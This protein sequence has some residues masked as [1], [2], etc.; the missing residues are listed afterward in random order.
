MKK[1]TISRQKAGADRFLP[2]TKEECSRRGWDAPDFVYAVGEAYVDHPSFGHAIISRVLEK[3]GYKVAMLCL[4]DWHTCD[5]FKR[6]GRPK[7]GYLVTAGVI[8]SMVNHYTAAKRRRNSDVYAPGGKS[9]MRPDRAVTVYCNRIHEAYP[10]LPILIGGVEASLRRFSHYDYWDDKVRR[11]VLVD[12]SATLLMYG[13]GEKSILECA[14]WLRDG[15]PAEQLPSIRGVCYMSKT[16]PEDA[17]VLPSHAEVTADKKAYAQSVIMEYDEA[18]PFRGRTLTQMQDTQR[19]LVQNPPVLPL[20]EKELDAVYDLPY[21]RAYHPVYE[22]EGGVPALQEVRFSISAVRGCFGACSFCALTFHQGRIVQ[23]RSEESLLKEARMLTQ[24]PDFKGYIHDVG[25]P[26]ANFRL[27]SCQKQ[28]K[29]GCCVNRQCLFPKPCPHMTVSHKAFLQTLRKMRQIPGVKKVFVRS[30]LRFDYIMADPEREKVIR[31][32]C[33]YHIS[34][35]LK[36]APEHISDA[37]LEQM[38][39]PCN[40]VYEQFGELYAKTNEQ[41]GMKQYL[42]PYLMSSHPGSTL[43]DAVQLALYLKHKGVQPEQ[44]QDFY[45]T[46]GT[47]S[48]CAYY[49][50]LDPRTMKPVF[51]PKTQREKDMQRALLQ[52][53]EP[54]NHPLIR[55]ALRQCGREDLIGYGHNALVPPAHSEK[56]A[57]V[58]RNP[59]PKNLRKPSK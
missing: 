37:V 39:K 34:G 16:A 26:T 55:Q 22:K 38:G 6:F 54:K 40:A 45:P 56:S 59:R 2:I 9:G 50:G 24:F 3:A 57:R 51:V 8:D 25:G 29:Y 32:L 18:D 15:M 20:T 5:D 13:M 58:P 23:S 12:S 52:W 19:W 48:T 17:V 41:L 7:L 14:Q 43:N 44:V 28:L 53:R 1:E 33:K 27:P 47:L 35:Q 11:S 31:E 49:T 10:G 21:T 30:G 36:V 42:V 4:P 46:P